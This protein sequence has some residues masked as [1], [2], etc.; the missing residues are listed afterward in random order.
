[1]CFSPSRR[2][3]RSSIAVDIGLLHSQRFTTSHVLSP[4]TMNIKDF[5]FVP[6]DILIPS[7]HT[8]FATSHFFVHIIARSPDKTALRQQINL[9]LC[10]VS[11]PQSVLPVFTEFTSVPDVL[12]QRLR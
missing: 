8:H 2:K 5:R 11:L 7:V 9:D 4:V 1:M 10:L 12:G 6:P 3:F